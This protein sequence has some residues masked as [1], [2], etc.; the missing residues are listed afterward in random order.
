MSGLFGIYRA[1]DERLRNSTSDK[2]SREAI[3]SGRVGL[4]T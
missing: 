1:L 4:R 2:R 3:I